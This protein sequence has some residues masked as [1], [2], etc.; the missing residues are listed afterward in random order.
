[1]ERKKTWEIQRIDVG[2][3]GGER[4]DKRG[5]ENGAERMRGE[6]GVTVTK[7]KDVKGR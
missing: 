2:R 5:E 6:K 4:G 1:M 7:R 3:R